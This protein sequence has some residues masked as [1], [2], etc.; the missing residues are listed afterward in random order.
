[1]HY[2]E[3]PQL[4]DLANQRNIFIRARTA[5]YPLAYYAATILDLRHK[6]TTSD[7]HDAVDRAYNEPRYDRPHVNVQ[8]GAVLSHIAT[9]D[10]GEFDAAGFIK[11]TKLLPPYGTLV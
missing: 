11:N 5:L 6:H 7:V 4:H 10:T 9:A 1:M 8:R 2:R 3:H